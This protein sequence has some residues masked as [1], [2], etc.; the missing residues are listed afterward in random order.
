[1]LCPRKLP[2]VET[3]G[4][5]TVICSDKT[6]TLT[7][8]QMSVVQL[9]TVLD[10]SSGT[11]RHLRVS[12]AAG[13]QCM[14]AHL[15]LRG[16]AAYALCRDQAAT[17]C[18]VLDDHKHACVM[19]QAN[20]LTPCS[21]YLLC[22]TPCCCTHPF[23]CRLMVLNCMLRPAL[24]WCCCCAVP[25]GS[26]YNPDQGA[27]EGLPSSG[28]DQCLSCIAEVCAVCNESKLDC[29]GGVFKAVGAPTEASLKVRGGVELPF[30]AGQG[31]E[32]VLLLLRHCHTRAGQDYYSSSHGD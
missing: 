6:G 29:S 14:L 5:T 23:A 24:C 15:Q 31:L 12:G 28:L 26:T 19:R 20:L 32:P 4:C 30:V 7:T 13:K 11:M 2:S 16:R 8:N 27:V 22:F 17:A 1:M 25:T 3:L 9:S 21:R 10:G 18:F